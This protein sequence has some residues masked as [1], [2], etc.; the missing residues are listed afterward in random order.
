M[1]DGVDITT[2]IPEN[3]RITR[4]EN[5]GTELVMQFPSPGG[6]R[7]FRYR[8]HSEL[9]VFVGLHQDSW[10]NVFKG[11]IY[12]TVPVHNSSSD[13][14]ELVAFDKLGFMEHELIRMSEF[15]NRDGW[16]ISTA[17]RDVII[18]SNIVDD[19][20][21][22]NHM[23]SQPTSLYLEQDLK[24]FRADFES[25]LNI[26]RAMN[27]LNV[28]YGPAP[29]NSPKFMH[30]YE[31]LDRFMYL[32]VPDLT[33]D[34]AA[35]RTFSNGA[36]IFDMNPEESSEDV[37]VQGTARGAP[38]SAILNPPSVPQ[39]QSQAVQFKL[40]SV[41]D[42]FGRWEKVVDFSK[43]TTTDELSTEARNLVLANML[44]IP[45]FSIEVRDGEFIFPNDVVEITNTVNGFDGKYLVKQIEITFSSTS[46]STRISV[47]R[48][49]EVPTSF[50]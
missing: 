24:P 47:G 33:L 19:S 21:Y 44:P 22:M 17:I 9:E 27:S 23:T 43:I 13:Y 18:G 32:P 49:P 37:I 12:R 26:V 42:V 7:S 30:F 20:T 3:C 16:E 25:R 1:H 28:N 41:E 4:R 35:S 11:R 34:P 29:T 45:S 6:S 10:V 15:D 39:L 5:S 48:V 8:H 40:K 38:D 46:Y 50:F 31:H 36:D 2:D 14:V